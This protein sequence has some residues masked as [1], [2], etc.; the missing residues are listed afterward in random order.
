MID[1]VDVFVTVPKQFFFGGIEFAIRSV[2]GKFFGKC[3]FD[4]ITFHFFAILKFPWNDGPLINGHHR[5]CNYLV[6]IDTNHRAESLAFRT[7]PIRIVEIE[8]MW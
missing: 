3:F 2:D 8:H 7:C 5:V 6:F 4:K 1:T